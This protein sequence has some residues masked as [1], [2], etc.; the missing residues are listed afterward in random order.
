MQV[1]KFNEQAFQAI[2]DPSR[3]H[4]LNLLTSGKLSI[5]ALAENFEM[6]RPAVSKHIKMLYNAGFI[7][8]EEK[9]RERYCRLNQQGFIDL[10]NWINYYDYFWHNK[11]N[12]LGSLLDKK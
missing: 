2:A 4:I 7:A 5:S 10:Q 9:G 11:M 3:R 12:K 8:I 6:S 1:E